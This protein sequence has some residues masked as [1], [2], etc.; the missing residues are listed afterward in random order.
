[1]AYDVHISKK[2]CCSCQ[3]FV[4]QMAQGQS[5]VPC[6]HIYYI[7]IRVFGMDVNH[8]MCIHHANLGMDDYF[9]IGG[10]C[11]EPFGSF[12]MIFLFLIHI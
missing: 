9:K 7:L 3:D 6:K 12:V 5:Y 8:N 2:P 11:K 4:Q 10:L 1:M